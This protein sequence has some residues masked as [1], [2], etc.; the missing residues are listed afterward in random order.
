MSKENFEHF[1]GA[2]NRLQLEGKSFVV[3]TLVFQQ[4]SSPQDLGARAIISSE[5]LEYGTVGGGKVEQK[6]IS[7]AQLMMKQK[8]TK[9]VF[10]TWNLQKDIGMTCGGVVNF[11]FEYFEFKNPFQIVVFGAGHIA[12]E[13]IPLLLKLD[14]EISCLDHRLD[15]LNKL[16]INKKLKTIH[17]EN[18]QDQ[19]K[20]LPDNSYVTIMT[21]G[22]STDLP[23]LI[24]VM[25][26][27]NR[28]SYVGNIGSEQK[29]LRL[30]ADLK[31]A[32]ITEEFLRQFH[33][34]MGENFGN[35]SPIEIAF[36]IVAQILKIKEM[37]QKEKVT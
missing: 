21:M 26:Q 14:C 32:G 19:V 4:G 28:F 24:E 35:N 23:I 7:E 3:A 10:V 9:T 33:C 6:V 25:K 2:F 5:G 16:P 12:Q 20:N 22:H 11:F 30:R 31:E 17:T 15:W 37:I 13:L 34:P 18:P 8:N 29:A 1:L 27:R 36:S